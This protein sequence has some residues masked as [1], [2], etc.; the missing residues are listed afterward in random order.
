MFDVM[1]FYKPVATVFH[2]QK[3]IQLSLFS[4]LAFF[5]IFFVIAS[6]L[7]ALKDFSA[8]PG[9]LIE[10]FLRLLVIF[11]ILLV[12]VPFSSGLTFLISRLYTKKEKI[13]KFIETN[14]FLVAAASPFILI[15]FMPFAEFAGQI[16]M[17]LGVILYL[18]FAGESIEMHFGL[19][20]MKSF[21]L[22]LLY[23]IVFI[24]FSFAGFFLARYLSVSII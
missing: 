2:E 1:T 10:L 22:S 12:H 5:L 3:K 18:Y 14:Y 16:L 11:F 15:F 6:F 21:L 8:F 7:T 4:M 17:A 24:T 13:G 20:P 23:I 19:S 9:S